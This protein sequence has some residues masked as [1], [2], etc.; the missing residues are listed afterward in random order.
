MNPLECAVKNNTLLTYL[1]SLPNAG[2]KHELELIIK[3]L[4]RDNM[5]DPLILQTILTLR[6]DTHIWEIPT[7]ELC[8]GLINMLKY[9]SVNSIYCVAEGAALLSARIKYF[10]RDTLTISA[11][12]NSEL[13]QFVHS[14]YA[15]HPVDHCKIRDLKTEPDATIICSWL[16][17]SVDNELLNYCRE[18][19]PKLV[20]LI[21]EPI[22]GSCQSRTFHRKMEV[23]NYHTYQFAFKQICQIDYVLQDKHRIYNKHGTS[24]YSRSCVT[25]YCKQCINVKEFELKIGIEYMDQFMPMVDY[26]KQDIDLAAKARIS[27]LSNDVDLFQLTKLYMNYGEID[28]LLDEVEGND[29]ICGAISQFINI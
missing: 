22:G 6:Y 17:Y 2:T 13:D 16:H 23:L 18:Y 28:D 10:A 21:G 29:K 4:E 26:G 12:T 3:D 24:T 20:I 1:N 25:I 7:E 27:R 11:S 9:F 15:Y 8:K 14:M 5:S 19:D